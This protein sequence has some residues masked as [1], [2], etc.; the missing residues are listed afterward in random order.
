MNFAQENITEDNI[1]ASELTDI[2]ERNIDNLDQSPD[3]K[4][5]DDIAKTMAALKFVPKSVSFGRSR[6]RGGLSKS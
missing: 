2:E 6:Q 4:S 1:H 3:D 5:M